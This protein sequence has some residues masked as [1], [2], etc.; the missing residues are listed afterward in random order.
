M[1]KMKIT[2]R[3]KLKSYVFFCTIKKGGVFITQQVGS[4]NERDLVE[5]V[6]PGISKPYPHA[7]LKEQRTLF[8]EN[9]FRILDAQEVYRPIKFY[10]VGA[11]VWFARIIKWEFPEFSVEKCY[12]RLLKMQ[13]RIEETG[14]IEGTTHRY[15][16]VAQKPN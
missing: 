7:N 11:F 3:H 4:E 15:M 6:L 10:D 16:I 1:Y 2:Y 5:M 9:G 13:Q 12:E 14:V 8:V